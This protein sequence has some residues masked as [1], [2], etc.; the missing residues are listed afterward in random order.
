MKLHTSFLVSSSSKSIFFLTELEWNQRKAAAGV[1]TIHIFALIGHSDPVWQRINVFLLRTVS[2]RSIRNRNPQ[3]TNI[4]KNIYQSEI[5][6]NWVQFTQPWYSSP[7]LRNRSVTY[8]SFP[9][10]LEETIGLFTPV[11]TSY[12]HRVTADTERRLHRRRSFQKTILSAIWQKKEQKPK[13]KKSN[14]NTQCLIVATSLHPAEGDKGLNFLS[15]IFG[16]AATWQRLN[17]FLLHEKTVRWHF[18]SW[19]RL[20]FRLG[21]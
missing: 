3:M 10:F 14:N 16:E 17:A 1:Q 12:Y 15:I 19:L 6:S 11:L 13:K 5:Y 9:L 2:Y 8:T 4:W 21:M 18:C 7:V 20:W